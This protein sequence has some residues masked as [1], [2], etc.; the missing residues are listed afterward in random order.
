MST[1]YDKALLVI[2]SLLVAGAIL[3]TTNQFLLKMDYDF[4]VE[5]PC[6]AGHD[7]CF[8]RDCSVE[9]CPPNGLE[10]YR[11]FV[12]PANEFSRCTN[13]SCLAECSSQA[14][15]CTEIVCGD[16]EDDICVQ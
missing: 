14:I 9:E 6:D 7:T 15:A 16:S 8:S 10:S 4:V 12:V 11:V 3:A 2:S 1:Y 13:D 5:A